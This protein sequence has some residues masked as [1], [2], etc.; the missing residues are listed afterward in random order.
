MAKHSSSFIKGPSQETPPAGRPSDARKPK[1]DA[2]DCTYNGYT[3]PGATLEK[4]SSSPTGP[5]QVTI[6]KK[7]LPGLPTG[8]FNDTNEKG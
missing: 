6:Q 5:E 8:L 2:T 4:R 7:P 3:I 1:S